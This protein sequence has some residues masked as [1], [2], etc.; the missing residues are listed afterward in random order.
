MCWWSVDLL[1]G[2]VFFHHMGLGNQGRQARQQMPLPAEPSL[3]ELTV[4]KTVSG[5]GITQLYQLAPSV[6]S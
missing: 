3:A 1:C 6:H 2:T 5:R 4:L